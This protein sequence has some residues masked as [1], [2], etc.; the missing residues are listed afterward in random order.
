MRKFPYYQTP[1]FSRKIKITKQSPRKWQNSREEER[2]REREREREEL[3]VDM[4]N[5]AIEEHNGSRVLPEHT[6]SLTSGGPVTP[7]AMPLP[8]SL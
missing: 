2:E 6:S 4:S 8:F 7:L 5:G 3:L 1:T